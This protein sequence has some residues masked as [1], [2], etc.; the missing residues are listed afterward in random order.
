MTTTTIRMPTTTTTLDKS[1]TTPTSTGT[2][3]QSADALIHKT[4]N[5]IGIRG[6]FCHI[7]IIVHSLS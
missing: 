6:I 5:G 4:K 1:I 2:I 7:A 3:T